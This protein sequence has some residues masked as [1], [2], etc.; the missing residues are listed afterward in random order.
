MN[1]TK[2]LL[3]SFLSIIS[4]NAF[5]QEEEFLS[6]NAPDSEF[7]YSLHLWD[8]GLKELPD[9]FASWSELEVL[10]LDGNELKFLPPSITKLSKL[11]EISIS[12]NQLTAFPKE[13]LEL[14]NL[15]SL[16]LNNNKILSV[17]DEIGSL[18]QLKYLL[19][20][21]TGINKVPESVCQLKNLE[22]LAMSD[23]QVKTLPACLK[24]LPKLEYLYVGENAFES[25]PSIITELVH[26]KNLSIEQKN[27]YEIPAGIKNLKNLETLYIDEDYYKKNKSKIEK[28]LPKNCQI[29][30]PPPPPPT[31]EVPEI[32]EPPQINQV[33]ANEYCF[34]FTE[35]VKKGDDISET[36]YTLEFD[37]FSDDARLV[38]NSSEY[39][40]K[41]K[42]EA[43]KEGYSIVSLA[44]LNLFYGKFEI[45][46]GKFIFISDNG[47]QNLELKIKYE[48]DGKTIQ[49]LTNSKK[50][51]WKKGECYAAPPS[52]GF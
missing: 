42:L 2:F 27:Q 17:P 15:T 8:R 4:M 34:N 20:S 23:N 14:K 30:P 26:L 16:D 43:E 29:N 11:R 9:N 48:T 25:F 7:V 37:D 52:V 5:A 13:V 31:L 44:D 24:D 49:E 36:Q 38:T 35:K 19:I 12:G 18:T 50:Q 3:C 40:E 51:I 22:L 45:K 39:N 47:N 46:N 33:T 1:L 41:E 32:M 6:G 10:F 28:L 21:V